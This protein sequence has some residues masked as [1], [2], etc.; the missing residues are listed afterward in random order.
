MHVARKWLLGPNSLLHV[1][2]TVYTGDCGGDAFTP[3]LALGVS[4]YGDEE[5]EEEA[6]E[7]EETQRRSKEHDRR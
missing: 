4:L 7:E 5:E 1:F 6:E 2:W 3:L